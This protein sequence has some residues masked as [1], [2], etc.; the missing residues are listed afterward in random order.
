MCV[1]MGLGILRF[2]AARMAYYLDSLDLSIQRLSNEEAAL[3]QEISALAAP[4]KIYSY[5]KEQLGMQKLAEAETLPVHL[6]EARVARKKDAPQ[7]KE[8]WRMRLAW[9]FGE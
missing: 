3:K 8:G 7:E 4:I 5:C 9:L 2:H 6:R 1:I